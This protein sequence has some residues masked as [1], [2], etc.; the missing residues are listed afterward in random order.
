MHLN[1]Y[2]AIFFGNTFSNFCKNTIDGV[3]IITINV[4]WFKIIIVNDGKV[5][6]KFQ[7]KKTRLIPETKIDSLFSNVQFQIE[8]CTTYRL[9]KNADSEGILLHT[10]ED[11][12]STLK[13]LLK[14]FILRW[15]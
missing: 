12:P 8:G 7:T 4:I 5:N 9:D 10:R 2:R 1:R 6:Y 3:M 15:K 14:I 13:C 11:T